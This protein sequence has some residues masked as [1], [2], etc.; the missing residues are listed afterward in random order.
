MKRKNIFI[1][2]LAIIFVFSG[3]SCQKK[4]K[5]D[6]EKN[7]N[8]YIDLKDKSAIN[9]IKFLTDEYKKDNPDTK[10]K[11]NDVLGADNIASDIS[12]GTM[13]DLII[14]ARN[15]MIELSEKGLI[16]DMG[17]YY[18]KNK[19][20]DSFYNI[21]PAYGR[22]GD[23]YYGISILPFS[24]EV[25]YNSDA[26]NKL[27]ITPL[28]N[29]KDIL[30]IAKRLNDNNVKIP[31]VVPEDLDINLM[32][33]SIIASN[34]MKIS[35]LDS[36]YD[37]KDEYKKLNDMQTLFNSINNLVRTSSINKKLF[38]LGNESSFT[39]LAKG[40]IPMVISY[41]YYF[42]KIKAE[43]V[44][45]IE[46]YI[47]TPNKKEKIPVIVNSLICMPSNGKNTEEAG[48]F[49]KY[50]IGDETQKMLSK[51]DYI[52][53]SKKT[54]ENLV[55]TSQVVAKHLSL[56]DDNSIIYAYSMPGKLHSIISGK[57]DNILQGKYTGNEWQDIINEA[58]K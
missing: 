25:Y 46:N 11:I 20:N 28:T 55:G 17:Q 36:I 27:G 48:K 47:V 24:F 44:S 6:N 23:K 39:A 57:I 35:S 5:G 2:I 32:L 45:L 10:L 30:N 8:I 53:S 42:N 51:K 38:E 15:T 29:I 34:T 14:T 12:K 52:T 9:I 4:N 33:S 49:I 31:V 56:A 18:E 1:L 21:I 3:I 7:L 43:N 16:S 54:N 22:V 50:V 13:A 19:I 40:N 41:A 37:N 58:Y 26:L